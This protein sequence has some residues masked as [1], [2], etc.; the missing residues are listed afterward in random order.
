[1]NEKYSMKKSIIALL[2]ALMLAMSAGIALADGSD[3]NDP[4]DGGG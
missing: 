1:M 4:S 2:T 3:P